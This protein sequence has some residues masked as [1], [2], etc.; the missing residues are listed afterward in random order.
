MIDIDSYAFKRALDEH[1]YYITRASEMIGKSPAYLSKMCSVGQ[2]PITSVKAIE[3]VLH[4][5]QEEYEF[6]K[7]VVKVA[8]NQTEYRMNPALRAELLELMKQAV[9][10]VLAE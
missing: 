9:R 2:M 10:E 5:K 8:E 6:K 7:P 1:G 3:Y 4:I